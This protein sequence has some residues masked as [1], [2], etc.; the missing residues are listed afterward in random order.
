MP[1]LPGE[2]SPAQTAA[3]GEGEHAGAPDREGPS[4]YPSRPVGSE[5]RGRW[6]MRLWIGLWCDRSEAGVPPEPGAGFSVSID[7]VEMFTAPPDCSARRTAPPD[8]PNG[9]D[10][11]FTLAEGRHV[12]TV[13]TPDGIRESQPL[14]IR[15]D[16]WVRIDHR[17]GAESQRFETSITVG[18]EALDW[19]RDYDPRTRPGAPGAGSEPSTDPSAA[20]S[21]GAPPRDDG[22]LG[23]D[24][25]VVVT[26][27]PGEPPR[28]RSSDGDR[29]GER[30]GAPQR[31]HAG[32][33]IV[34]T[35]GY[36]RVQSVV[37]AEVWIDGH[38]TGH[39]T[40][41][42]DIALSPGAY[43]VELR[44]TDGFSRTFS[45]DVAPGRVRTIVNSRA[46]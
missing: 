37:P 41:T 24:E 40:P 11:A 8:G 29:A 6:E 31:D 28:A 26:S 39:S 42:G 20:P 1:G 33:W 21:D 35:A 23:A 32:N 38:A 7:G 45:V 36:L 10:T 18:T 12:L 14:P 27:E 9:G 15:D 25:G 13:V 19:D 34:G 43:R 44:G 16:T 2:T 22:W 3:P 4:R 30:T 5:P 17:M 46:D